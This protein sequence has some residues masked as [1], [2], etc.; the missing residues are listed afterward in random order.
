MGV[1]EP[2]ESPGPGW[3]GGWGLQVRTPWDGEFLQSQVSVWQEGGVSLWQH[4]GNQRFLAGLGRALRGADCQAFE[5]R[6]SEGKSPKM[7]HR[8]L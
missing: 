3:R 5:K 7:I 2:G 4:C 8:V 1:A 6:S